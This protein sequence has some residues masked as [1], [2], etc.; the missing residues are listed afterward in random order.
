MAE[1]FVAE[2]WSTWAIAI[3]FILLR[4]YARITILGWRKLAL[5]DAFMACAA[6]TYTAETTAAYFVAAKWLGLANSGMTDEQRETLNPN[7]EEWRFRVNGSKTHVLLIQMGQE[8]TRCYRD[9][10][11][12]FQIRIK[13]GYILIATTASLCGSSGKFSQ[14]LEV[15]SQIIY[16]SRLP[17]RKKISLLVLF[18]GGFLVIA[19]GILRCVSLLTVGAI[20]PALSGEWSVRE[21]F[22]AVLVS[23]LP[24]VL[25][26]LQ[27]WWSVV[28]GQPSNSSSMQPS[29]PLNDEPQ[30]SSRSKKKHGHPLFTTDNTAWASDEAIVAAESGGTAPNQKNTGSSESMDTI[31]LAKKSG[32]RTENNQHGGKFGHKNNGEQKGQ[33]TVIEEYSVYESTR[34]GGESTHGN[35][36]NAS[37]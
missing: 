10:L 6:L 25:P 36:T 5:D 37:Y 28:R 35:W 12:K 33:I 2:A 7:S 9:G 17:T 20:K 19:F 8:L 16:K 23:N 4:F 18:S 30:H 24:M 13:I 26:L 11:V 31:E 1:N 21:S 34:D 29:Y 15:N 22:I 32:V 14:T 3:C 27:L